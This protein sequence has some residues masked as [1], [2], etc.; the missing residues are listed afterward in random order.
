MR[1]KGDTVVN[2]IYDWTDTEVWEYIRGN[3]IQYNPMYDMGYWRVGCVLCPMASYREKKKEMVDFPGFKERYVK[4]FE[5]MIEAI[6]EKQGD[7]YRSDSKWTD[8]ES[9]FRWYIQQDEH[10]VKGQMS[11]EDF[12]KEEE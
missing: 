4:A 9:C 1:Q 3:N 11:I 6:K 5:R 12:L 8:G 7:K 2:I 10:E